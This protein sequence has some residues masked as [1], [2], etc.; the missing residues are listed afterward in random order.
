MLITKVWF[1]RLNLDDLLTDEEEISLFVNTLLKLRFYFCI[2]CAV[3]IF[4]WVTQETRIRMEGLHRRQLWSHG[5]VFRVN[6]H[7]TTPVGN[8]ALSPLI[9]FRPAPPLIDARAS[10][11]L[12]HI[13][14]S[15]PLL[16]SPTPMPP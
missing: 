6:S 5:S 7:P 3:R 16:K 15:S 11:C 1:L 12:T 13:N 2:K 14:A 10:R 9:I 4:V 8:F